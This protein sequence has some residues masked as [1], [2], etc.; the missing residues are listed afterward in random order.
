L[1]GLLN[2]DSPMATQPESAQEPS[3]APRPNPTRSFGERLIGAARLDPMVYED[4]EADVSAT[5]QAVLV[6]CLSGVSLAIGR[7]NAGIEGVASSMLREMVG[8]LLISAIVYVI[9]DKIL[10]GSAT[11]G[12]L[13]R[14][15]GF[16]QAPGLLAALSWYPPINAP[17]RYGIATWKLFAVVVAIRQALDF[18]ERDWGTAR[19]L[20]TA[21]LGFVVYVG[22]AV[23]QAW[24]L[25]MPIIPE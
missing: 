5:R 25:G 13:L 9:G 4:V 15:I 6:V 10:R 1:N 18:D 21:G 19:A 11:W 16:A 8:W 7:A 23:L 2:I 20:L 3:A 22:L 24:L 17:V 12:E 14:T